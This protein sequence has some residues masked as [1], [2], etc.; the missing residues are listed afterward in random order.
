[1]ILDPLFAVLYTLLKYFSV[2]IFRRMGWALLVFLLNANLN[3]QNVDTLLE[4]LLQRKEIHK[5]LLHAKDREKHFTPSTEAWETMY[6]NTR[7]STI[8]FQQGKYMEGELYAKRALG[9]SMYKKD[10]ILWAE[11]IFN[12]AAA[13][14]VRRNIDTVK[15]LLDQGCAYARKSNHRELNRTC[16]SMKG[17]LL[18]SSQQEKEAIPFYQKALALTRKHSFH[19]FLSKDLLS[20]ATTYMLIEPQKCMPLLDEAEKVCA[21]QKDTAM[22]AM[23]YAG[24]AMHNL[25]NQQ[26][27]QWRINNQKALQYALSVKHAPTALYSYMQL[28]DFHSKNKQFEEAYQIGIESIRYAQSESIQTFDLYLYQ[29]MFEI[30]KA[31]QKKDEAIQYLEE[32]VG[33]KTKSIREDQDAAMNMLKLQHELQENKLLLSNKELALGNAQKRNLLLLSINGLLLCLGIAYYLIRRKQKEHIHHLYTKEKLVEQWIAEERFLRKGEIQKEM[34]AASSVNQ[35]ATQTATYDDE[36]N[37]KSSL[38][39]ELILTIEQEKLY[40]NPELNQKNVISILG[41]NRNYL[42]KAIQSNSDEN[43]KQIINRYRVEEAKNHIRRAVD[44]GDTGGY[45]QF[46]TVSG[47][48]SET[49]FY[50]AFK[51]FTGL[52]P[53]EFAR[54]YARD[55]HP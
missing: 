33:I 19:W 31:L 14:Q 53:K 22:L 38:F 37:S 2:I 3:G 12:L 9:T 11:A 41:T 39:K 49:S 15:I 5:A 20:L 23:V 32:Y 21:E 27:D 6:I 52:S 10:S 18:M 17:N 42:N 40:L 28:L 36:K 48:N 43:F 24:R 25:V 47:F 8:L 55:I 16:F 46:S 44:A 4:G 50:R 26:I 7:L 51:F 30:C 1:M 54:E 13:Y 45:E 35:V 29:K 34:P